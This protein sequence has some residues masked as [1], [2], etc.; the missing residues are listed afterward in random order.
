MKLQHLSSSSLSLA[1]V[2]ACL[3]ITAAAL[4]SCGDFYTYEED[5]SQ[6]KPTMVLY[7]DTIDI[8]AGDTCRLIAFVMPAVSGDV[9]VE[10][11]SDADSI[12]TVT[13]DSLLALK[14]GVCKVVARSVVDAT[15]A[16]TCLVRVVGP[17][18]DQK[19]EYM[20][21]TVVYADISV[22]GRQPSDMLLVGAFVAGELRGV[23]VRQ[24][25]KGI[26][27]YVFRISGRRDVVLGE[28]IKFRAI[29]RS[30]FKLYEFDYEVEF[31]GQSHGT[32]SNLVSLRID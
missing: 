5:D 4:C 1:R 18:R 24:E 12:A 10:W 26:P 23:P 19:G 29:D 9:G 14:A 27:Y 30:T 15:V 2:A 8:L 16:D 11:E 3:L 6:Q 28:T 22:H 7:R 32:L 20:N 17:W 31:D 25:W 21:E 13:G